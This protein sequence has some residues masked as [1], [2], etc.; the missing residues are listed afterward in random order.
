MNILPLSE[1]MFTIDSTK[2]FIP[3]NPEKDD[4]Q[5]RPRG[6]LLVEIQPF[7]VIRNGVV[8][9]LDTGLGFKTETGIL[10][11]HSN[12]QKQ[13]IQPEEVDYVLLSHLHKDHAGGISSKGV[14]N[15]SNARYV[16]HE[17]E[18]AFALEKGKPSY[19][20]DDFSVLINHPQLQLLKD[21]SGEVIPGVQFEMVG[22]HC[23]F[24]LAYRLEEAGDIVF[25]GGDVA[26]Q[27]HQ[28]KHRY[29]AKYDYDGKVSVE[30]RTRWWEKGN[31]EGWSFLFYHDIKTPVYKGIKV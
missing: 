17:K 28:M 13:G 16:I 12:L 23:P 4:L 10:Q 2:D 7:C 15:F 11:I 1:G 21:D 8:I 25:F 14:L 27:L 26:P 24:H 31:R 5:A 29:V 6:S 3:F 30:W 19:D 9:L 22:G 18:M 20:T